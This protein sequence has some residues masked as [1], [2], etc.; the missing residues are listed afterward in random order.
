MKTQGTS[1]K[2]LIAA[3]MSLA[4]PNDGRDLGEVSGQKDCAPGHAGVAS[5]EPVP[6]I[7]EAGERKFLLD[8][9]RTTLT[10]V[11]TNGPLPGINAKDVPPKLARSRGCFVTLREQGQLRG[12]VGQLLPQEPLYLAVEDNAQNAAMRD[13]R[14]L[15]VRAGEVDKIKIEI[16]VLSEPQPLR[17]RSPEELVGQLKPDEGVVLKIGSHSATYLPQVWE[18]LPG[19]IEFLN[20]LSKKAGCEPSAW[21]D[22]A[23]KVA[24]YH[25]QA[26]EEGE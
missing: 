13:R 12:C 25:V 26:F 22:K 14:F 6:E 20:Q 15:P 2:G 1:G 21:R 17:F 8:L 5:S 24:I 3:V 19:K 9:A 4:R 23:A 16:S 10:Q 18:Q 7:Y 11:A